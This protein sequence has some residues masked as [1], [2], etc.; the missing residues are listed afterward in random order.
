MY[1]AKFFPARTVFSFYNHRTPRPQFREF[2][3]EFAL[4]DGGTAWKRHC[5]FGNHTELAKEICK[6]NF[7]ALHVGAVHDNDVH[8][9]KLGSAT[10]K[11]RELVFDLDLQDYSWLGAN[12]DDQAANDRLVPI[13]FASA[14][15]LEAALRLIFGFETF[16]RVYSGRRGAHL[17]VLDDRAFALSDE[18]R[19][20]VCAQVSASV[21]K[22]DP[23]L[24]F[25]KQIRENPNLND[26][27][28]DRAIATAVDRAAEILLANDDAILVF[29]NQLF[30]WPQKTGYADQHDRHRRA[31]AAAAVG[32]V[33]HATLTAIRTTTA[34][35][36]WIY[37]ARLDD[38]L[39]SLVWPKIDA[40]ATKLGHCVKAPFSL[41]AK[42]G[43]V[44]LP[45]SSW[46][47]PVPIVL[48]N[49]MTTIE[50]V[51]IEFRVGLACIV[52]HAHMAPKRPLPVT[53]PPGAMPDLEDLS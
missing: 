20:A 26:E 13:L 37:K 8:F 52:P 34:T 11:Q 18:A 49:C 47:S 38:V 21:D 23:R 39:L 10:P 32:K 25:C 36:P 35:Q 29:V 19:K 15:I 33:G 50:S 6:P 12:R 42:T 28:V 46:D 22:F 31:V 9:A 41:H 43:R 27:S 24:L 3:V 48:G 2:A 44:A 7:R 53:K 30:D 4:A 40:A 1:H 14:A 5:A 45:I 51:P 16:L 17:Y